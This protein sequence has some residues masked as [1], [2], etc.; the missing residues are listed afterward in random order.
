MTKE[1]QKVSDN[2]KMDVNK[3]AEVLGN[4]LCEKTPLKE[5]IAT[6]DLLELKRALNPVN[7]MITKELTTKFIRNLVA[8]FQNTPGGLPDEI[9]NNIDGLINDNDSV[10]VNANGYDFFKSPVVAEVKANIP[11]EGD[12]YGASQKNGLIKDLNGLLLDPEDPGR[13]KKKRGRDL[14]NEYKFLVVLDY[15]RFDYYKT[16]DAVKD[17]IKG[18]EFKDVEIIEKI[19]E[20]QTL[21]KKHVYIVMLE[22]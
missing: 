22:L 2:D 11:Y 4:I 12:K 15:K 19:N 14:T 8:I 13:P 10:N 16:L 9:R 21:D 18:D 6:S 5:E 3:L 20:P 7:N 1:K 17:L